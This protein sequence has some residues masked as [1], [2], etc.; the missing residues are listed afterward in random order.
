VQIHW[1]MKG[2]LAQ[3]EAIHR[4]YKAS[5]IKECCKGPTA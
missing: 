5:T 2:D 3:M 4:Q 1:R